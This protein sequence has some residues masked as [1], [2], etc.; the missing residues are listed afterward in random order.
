MGSGIF[1]G[2]VATISGSLS[3]TAISGLE[4]GIL[5]GSSVAAALPALI[6]SGAAGNGLHVYSNIT[7]SGNISGSST[8]DITVGGTITAEHLKST[9]NIEV[10]DD[11]VHSGDADTYLRFEDNLVNLVAGGKSAIKYEA[12]TGKIIINNTN[13]NVD[14]ELS[15]AV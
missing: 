5:S 9:D 15:D 14:F 12:S 1:S 8:S 3:N 2:S 4:A 6:I 13:R 7:A 11:V 10:A